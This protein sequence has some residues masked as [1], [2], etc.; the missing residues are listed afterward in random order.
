MTTSLDQSAHRA[1][2]H[3][4]A[5]S[6]LFEILGTWVATTA[7]PDVRLMLDR[8]SHHCAW[9]AEQ[10]W[11]RLPV[12]ADV[13]R[14]SLCAPAGDPGRA[15]RASRAADHLAR[16]E[17]PVAR[18]AAAYRVA[19][20]R[21]WAAY[22]RHRLAAG[23]AADGSSL[24]AIA[25]VAPDLAADWHEGEMVLQGMLEDAGKVTEAAAAV[26]ALEGIL[27]GG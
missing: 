22:E 27:T 11:D 1:G 16:L 23:T 4:W 2:A 13:D 20:P 7:D 18:L 21:Q 24:R 8:H 9:R 5:E 3:Q 6:R 10:W 12:L 14:R 17:D 25:I 15:A 26:A 19:L